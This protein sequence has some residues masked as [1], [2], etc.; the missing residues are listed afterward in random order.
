MQQI[1]KMAI[2][3]LFF[4]QSLLPMGSKP[5]V[6][7]YKIYY[8][9]N[10]LKAIDSQGQQRHAAMEIY[11]D[12]LD[13]ISPESNNTALTKLISLSLPKQSF[14]ILASAHL[15]KN[16]LIRSRTYDSSDFHSQNEDSQYLKKVMK[17]VNLTHFYWDIYDIP[18]TQFVLLIPKA[19]SKLYGGAY[20]KVP[21]LKEINSISASPKAIA[22]NPRNKSSLLPGEFENDKQKEE[23]D[24]KELIDWLEKNKKVIPF[25]AKHLSEIFINKTDTTS[26]I[27]DF[28]II[29][30]GGFGGPDP[31]IANLKPAIFNSMLSFFDNEIKTG[32][33]Y[34]VSCF[35][36][37]QNRTL[38]ETTKEGVQ[39]NHNFIF[40]LGAI[41]DKPVITLNELLND[42]VHTFFNNAGFIQDKGTG[43]NNLLRYL[44]GFKTTI[45]SPHGASGLPQIWLPGGYGF[46]TFNVFNH[47]LT[48]GNV[49]LKK[50]QE[51]KEFIDIENI[52]A[53][54]LYPTFIDVP[55][56]VHPFKMPGFI[57]KPFKNLAL[58]Y[59]PNFFENIDSKKQT[60]I[61][62]QLQ[63]ENLLPFYW[64]LEQV[65]AED[66]KNP[67]YY[68]YPQ[69][70]SM[71]RPFGGATFSKIIVNNKAAAVSQDAFEHT[72][73]ILQFIRDAFFDLDIENNQNYYIDELKGKND[74]SLT[75]AASRLA[76][77]TEEKHPLEE[78]LKNVAHLDI[79]LK[80][81]L[82][83][84]PDTIIGFQFENTAW[85][86]TR[87]L[88]PS[89]PTKMRWNFDRYNVTEYE[90]LYKS[91][92]NRLLGT[93]ENIPQKNISEILKEKQRQILLKQAVDLKKKQEAIQKT[94]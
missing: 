21:G 69:F 25:S 65:K 49:Y 84:W 22:T 43:L 8:D 44:S 46:Q 89:D 27:W 12:E 51:N 82:L 38:L 36:G 39:T 57:K 28:F 83:Q 11:I 33:I 5:Y 71:R 10:N 66:T 79:T 73:G 7:P 56:K 24:Y 91:E 40:I 88:F 55:L 3:C 70:I 68:L 74:I 76:S 19:F 64:N 58:V 48:I 78:V 85:I 6:E 75:L 1:I 45:S 93:P 59:E 18:Q 31:L 81:V 62:K 54:L 14:P 20:G 29:G 41:G 52:L 32:I 50:Y 60:K 80:N 17:E 92:R 94:Q 37:G 63:L 77:N 53:V 23:Y 34:V 61:I 9:A 16:L 13:E 86:L 90:K 87:A 26:P 42:E 72:R 30:H 2:V 4:N 15:I 67:N 47:F 35:A